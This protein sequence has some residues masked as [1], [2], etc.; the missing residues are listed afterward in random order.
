MRSV[1]YLVCMEEM[2]NVYKILVVNL[3]KNHSEGRGTGGKLI[4]ECSRA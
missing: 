1:G 4:L 2:R 3:E